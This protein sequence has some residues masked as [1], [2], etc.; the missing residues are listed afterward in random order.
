MNHSQT[1]LQANSKRNITSDPAVVKLKLENA[2][3]D[4]SGTCTGRHWNF[5]WESGFMPDANSNR[6]P[7]LWKEWNN[8]PML[9][10][11]SWH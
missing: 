2:P 4:S 11:R 8:E 5:P 7:Q 9:L 10:L 1:I 6:T 3:F